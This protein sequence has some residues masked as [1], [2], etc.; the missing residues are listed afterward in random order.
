M[1]QT[2]VAENSQSEP[3]FSQA[4]D[5]VGE[6]ENTDTN[7]LQTTD[8]GEEAIEE[9]KEGVNASQPAAH[10]E[11]VR[12]DMSVTV[13]EARIRQIKETSAGNRQALIDGLTALAKPILDLDN[14]LNSQFQLSKCQNALLLGTIVND[15]YPPVTEVF[16]WAYYSKETFPG[17][18]SST[19]LNY[20]NIAARLDC[21]PYFNLGVA[22]VLKLIKLTRN[23]KRDDRIRA[24]LEEHGVAYEPG[25]ALTAQL[26]VQ[27][28]EVLKEA[29]KKPKNPVSVGKLTANLKKSADE[30]GKASDEDL[31]GLDDVKKDELTDK[32]QEILKKLT[33]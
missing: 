6:E 33:D 25:E 7:A 20:R 19:L 5:W 4:E 3:L 28:D 8:P 22:R 11:E 30:F 16:K 32:L 13:L 1:E 2:A 27:I 31:E 23:D 14:K 18:S 12:E 17:V 24:F 9:E 21:H 26:K 15:L 29:A 10:I